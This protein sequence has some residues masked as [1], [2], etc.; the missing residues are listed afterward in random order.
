MSVGGFFRVCFIYIATATQ[1]AR[2]GHDV[3][4]LQGADCFIKGLVG[5]GGSLIPPTFYSD[6][7]HSSLSSY[8][9]YLRF[10][11]NGKRCRN[12]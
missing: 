11:P 6:C 7:I 3:G 10:H 8:R 9:V 2:N 5:L 12:N 4:V 1:K